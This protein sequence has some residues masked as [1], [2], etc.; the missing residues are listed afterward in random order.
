MHLIKTTFKLVCIG[1]FI[2]ANQFLCSC[3]DPSDDTPFNKK[4][5]AYLKKDLPVVNV[6]SD[7]YAAYFDFTGAMTACNDQETDAVFNGLCQ[8]IT[9]NAEHFDI[10]KMGNSE[11]SPIDGNVRPAEVFSQ[12]KGASDKQEFYAP[13]EKTLKKISDEGRSALLVTDFEEYTRDGQ[14]FTQAYA[15]P[16][17]KKWLASGGDITFF[18]TDYM[19]KGPKHLYYVV[20]DYNHHNLLKLVEDALQGL[21]KNYE[22]FTLATNSYPMSFDYPAASKGGT[23]HDVSGEDIISQSVE[24]GSSDGFFMLDSLRAESYVF[25]SG[26]EDIV[27]NAS[28]Q[29]ISNGVDKNEVFTHLFRHLFIDLSHSDSY[30]INEL[31]VNVADIQDDFDRFWAYQTA[32]KHKPTVK[33]EGGETYLDFD[34]H[35]ECEEY[36]DEKGNLLP[37]WDYSKSKGCIMEIHDMLVFDNEMFQASCKANSAKAE[38]G[39]YFNK[40]FNGNILQQK[41]PSDLLRIDIVVSN[42]EICPLDRIEKLFYWQGNDCLSASIKSVLQDMKPIGKPIYSYFVRIL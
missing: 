16:Y 21:P 9:G 7:K 3:G 26:W 39:I 28:F 8:K 12:L 18:V 1:S 14:I 36:F 17:F 27:T 34:G 19:E 11:I 23:F 30:K 2:L 32:I 35:D 33:K 22:R 25:G 37:E 42:A 4:L 10:Y 6:T 20:F 41:D 38:L 13:I 24:D 31:A 29:T 15:T 40:G 5:D